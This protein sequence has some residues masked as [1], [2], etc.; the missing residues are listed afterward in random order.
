LTNISLAPIL[1]KGGSDEKIF[2]KAHVDF[3]GLSI[4]RK[5]RR[6]DP[7]LAAESLSC[8]VCWRR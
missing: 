6:F 2:K 8:S 7:N 5:L 3:G 1:K 4:G